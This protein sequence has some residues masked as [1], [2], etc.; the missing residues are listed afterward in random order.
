VKQPVCEAEKK[1]TIRFMFGNGLK[2]DVWEIFQERFKVPL[3]AEFYGSTEG[4]LS[5]GL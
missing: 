3:I 2:P 1:H 4:N 5:L